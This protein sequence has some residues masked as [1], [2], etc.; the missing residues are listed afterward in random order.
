MSMSRLILFAFSCVFALAHGEDKT[1][2]VVWDEQQPAQKAAYENFL[3]NAI[4]DHLKKSS[5][6]DVKS[7]WFTQPEHGLSK[8]TLDNCDVLIWWEHTVKQRL[9][10]PIP[11]DIVARI[12]AGE[13]NAIMLH[14]AHWSSPFI[15]AMNEVTRDRIKEKYL[16]K[17]EG[18]FEVKY[19]HPQLYRA[20]NK[21]SLI[22]PHVDER[23]FPDGRVRL[24]VYLPNCCFP[25]Y[26]PDGAPGFMTTLMPDHPIAKGIPKTWKVTQTEMYDEP[27]N[28]PEP[29]AVIFEERW[30][31]NG[32]W[33]RSGMVWNIGKG[34]LFYFRPGHETYPV[35][36]E[37]LPLKI[38]ENAAR[39]LGAE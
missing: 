17:A 30:E 5:D 15:E 24:D 33:F 19:L 22:T 1:S 31:K 36:K 32:E 12:K 3:G 39:W 27:F 6:L 21:Q 18:K 2:V 10:M 38:I 16:D 13:L 23:R 25:G 26:R 34:K 4:A 9:P 29:D 11:K 8:S 37:E 14:S 20:P 7:V 28:V 35:Y